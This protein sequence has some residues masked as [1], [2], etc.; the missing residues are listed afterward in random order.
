MR[1]HHWLL[2]AGLALLVL[3]QLLASL[4]LRAA[5]TT[6]EPSGGGAGFAA[7]T[8]GEFA[9]TLL[10]GGFRGL[11]CDMLWMRADSAEE[12]KRFYESLALYQTISR[13]QPRFDDV[14]TYLSWD[15]AYN[16]GHDV[17]D[18]AAK[19]S[20]MQAGLEANAE[21]CRRNPQSERLLRHLAWMFNH[22][23]DLF[24]DAIRA[25][26]WDGLLQPLLDQVN[27]Q[28]PPQPLPPMPRT[29]GLSSYRIAAI[30]YRACVALAE[31]EHQP[32]APY[33]PRSVPLAI[34][35]DGD[36]A[37]NRGDHL[38]ALGIWLEALEE[39]QRVSR[40]YDASAASSDPVEEMRR[41]IGQESTARN[42]GR[43]RRKA[44]AMARVLAPTPAQGDAVADAILTRR[45][46]DA[47]AGLATGTWQRSARFG[48]IRWLDQ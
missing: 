11:A 7:V 20:W 15:M 3:G 13:V 45:F 29:A 34:E 10:L 43:L 21:G 25:R 23:G 37:R 19:W 1:R 36:T 30:L 5:R 27:R 33:T 14:W 2:A 40:R 32:V 48:R 26:R 35:G 47:R 31:A 42:E 4:P 16:I 28:H 44:A 9:G 24:G 22:R 41:Q 6:L 18:Q 12:Q 8:P 46:A 38:E 17:E 39:W